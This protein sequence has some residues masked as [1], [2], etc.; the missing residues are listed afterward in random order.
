AGYMLMVDDDA[1]D[2]VHFE[3]QVHQATEAYAAATAQGARL[4]LDSVSA[5]RR[6]WRGEPLADV[7]SHEWATAEITRLEERRLQ[8]DVVGLHSLL[9]L[10]RAQEAV[11]EAQALTAAH[12]LQ[13][14]FVALLML[15]LYRTGR[16]SEALAAYAAARRVLAEE[17][18]LDPGP[19]LQALERQI[20]NQEEDLQWVEPPEASDARALKERPVSPTT[21]PMPVTALLGRE[22]HLDEVRDILDLTRLLTV[23]GPGGVGKT[24]LAMEV[25]RRREHD[26]V[27]FV[28]LSTLA[29]PELV[30]PTVARAIGVVT[31]PATDLV[32]AVIEHIGATKGLL[33]L[34]GVEHLVDPTGDL[35]SRLHRSC[36]ALTTLTTSRRP[37]RLSGE[38]TWPLPPLQL[39][40]EAVGSE[41]D[42]VGVPSVELFVARARSARPGFA[43]TDLNA[44][45]VAGI[46]RTLDGLPLAIELAAGHAD[47][48]APDGLLQRLADHLDLLEGESRDSP[49]RQ[50]SLRAVIESS[51]ALLTAVE[52]R[53]FVLLGAFAGSFDL[54]GAGA[55][56]ASPPAESFRLTASLV[57]QSLVSVTATGRYRLLEPVRVFASEVLTS[58]SFAGEARGRHAEHLLAL[59]TA[60]DE[61]LRGKG[62]TLWLARI[63]ETLPDLR[64]ALAWSLGGGDPDLG[65]RLAAVSGWF[66]TLEGMLDEATGWVET[67]AAV[68]T[69]DDVARAGIL[70]AAGRIAAP[71]GDLTRARELCAQSVLI[72]RRIGDDAALARSLVTLGLAQWGLGELEEAGASHEEAAQRAHLVG[73]AWHRTA[74]LILRARTAID[75]GDDDTGPRIEAAVSAARQGHDKHLVGLALSQ[76]ARLALLTGAPM[77]AYENAQ[78]SLACWRAVG[79]LE[80]QINALTLLSRSA[81]A[82][83]QLTKA[84]QHAREAMVTAHTMGHRGGLLESLECFGAAL[85]ASGSAETAYRLLSA[86]A[87][88]RRESAIPV[89]AAYAP[90]TERLLQEVGRQLG[91]RAGSVSAAARYVSLGDLVD[92]LDRTF[93]SSR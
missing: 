14:Q 86:A 90:Q 19:E 37:L 80:G 51:V 62:Q 83:G 54:E 36:P 79:Y 27:W 81:L 87:S 21:I 50:R 6:L 72:S 46:V 57:R 16:Q 30:V 78:E 18:G 61:G 20:L 92:E 71:R 52:R 25:A 24:R 39:P 65:V 40:D 55:M 1:V 63:R 76:R 11:G 84:R 32:D 73:D 49:A 34:D 53:H 60:A 44:A 47:V 56:A 48:L 70:H 9:A 93:P 35:V 67:A 23:T 41:A 7:S 69:D 64:A 22:Q 10:G 38:V 8:A 74:A 5:A 43:V 75:Q 68:A 17:L 2:T 91:E 4:A 89:P 59:M 45:D 26:S 58:E 15:A 88:A 13:E 42:L 85:Y 82:G 31:R 77:T 29:A 28:D 12:P 66:W 33:V 3:R